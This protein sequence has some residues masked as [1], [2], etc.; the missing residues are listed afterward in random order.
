MFGLVFLWA[1]LACA[2]QNG[3]A[4]DEGAGDKRGH[5]AA[6]SVAIGVAVPLS[7]EYKALG[8]AVLESARVAV[9]EGGGRVVARDTLGTPAGAIAAVRQLAAD[10]TVLAILGPVGRRESRAAA[11]AAQRA[12]VPLF[13]LA[14]DASINQAGGWVYRLRQT[15]AEQAS[16]LAETV[17]KQ[18]G[19]A[20]RAGIFFPRS[21]YGRQAATA[22][23]ERFAQLGGRV[24]AAASYPD[25]ATDFRKALDELVGK[26]L[27]IGKHVRAGRQRADR[28]GYLRIRRDPVVDFDLV[29]IPD[30]HT[31]ISRILTFFPAAGLQNGEGGEGEAVQMLGL[32][33]WQ[34]A[35]MRLSG[36]IAAG[37]IYSDIFAIEADG[38]KAQEFAL[39]F[40]E[41]TGRR[42][43]NLDAEVFD[44]TWM[45]AHIMAGMQSEHTTDRSS[46]KGAAQ[47][48]KD[49]VRRRRSRV[50]AHLPRASR[51]T[52]A[53]AVFRGVTG[54][55]YFDA[56]G[57]PVR[58]TR[59]YQ[60]DIGGSVAPWR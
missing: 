43:V 24:T 27:H 46:S 54:V 20:P 32:S 39:L 22:F 9:G 2:Q 13:T 34:G 10:P 38:G 25:D 6:P 4:G 56:I 21:L 48:K 7:G 17:R 31:N 1:A 35:S 8:E 55:L 36:A 40:E 37:A 60:F 23:A 47:H 42:P 12:G 18:F 49:G 53:R 19:D 44:A 52:S 5:G 45:L 14:G 57:A 26:K 50:V 3:G 58:P 15:P 11:R 33:G 30:F 59:L 28:D 41:K 29:F 51:Q 16:A